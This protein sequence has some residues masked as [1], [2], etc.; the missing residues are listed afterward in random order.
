MEVP[1]ELEDRRPAGEGPGHP[2]R[3]QRRFGAGAGELHLLGRR[4][5]PARSAP[6]S[7][8][9]ARARRRSAC[10]AQLRLHRGGHP[11]RCDQTGASRDPLRSRSGRLPSTSHLCAPSALA[12][13]GG[14]GFM[15]R[16]S[17][18]IPPGM[19]CRERSYIA[20]DREALGKV[21]TDGGRNRSFGHENL[22]SAGTRGRVHVTAL[23]VAS[24]GT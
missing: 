23:Y 20:R 12:M 14:N 9:P 3:Q 5:E 21:L 2:D 8:P 18:V 7:A 4:H 11:G 24:R 13:Y 6:P 22:S 16:P 1:L 17:W 10:R 19:T 15:W